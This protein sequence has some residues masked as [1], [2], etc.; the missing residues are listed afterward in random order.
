MLKEAGFD[1]VDFS[2]CGAT[3]EAFLDENYRDT[4]KKIAEYMN[5][6]GLE[7]R[8][9][10]APFRFVYGEDMDG[11]CLHYREIER[12]IEFASI[13]GAK[14][15]I[16]HSIK[17][18]DDAEVVEYNLKYYK[19]FEHLCKKFNIQIGVENLYWIENIRTENE[20]YH[21]RFSKPQ[22]MKDFIKKL[23]SEWLVVCLDTSHAA[24]TGTKPEDFVAGMDSNMLKALH[25][26]DSDYKGDKHW[27]PFFGKHDWDA[28]M[29]NLAKIGYTGDLTYEVCAYT[30]SYD[31]ELI[32]AALEFAAKVGR[33][34]IKKFVEEQN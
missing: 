10:H 6:I 25:V 2:F 4:A 14:Y 33:Y 17:T 15:I 5:A 22:E 23:D 13:L 9:T 27:L 31:D 29:K 26:H 7:C 21:G 12:S 8:Q 1:A 28:F 30:P 16:I 19:S 34:L 24:A 20:K 32:P 18:P 11:S 3:G